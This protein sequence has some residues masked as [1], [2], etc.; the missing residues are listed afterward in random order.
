MCQPWDG[1][2]L[3]RKTH[4]AATLAETYSNVAGTGS[5][6]VVGLTPETV[7]LLR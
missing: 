7:I 1:D 6:T 5:I 3:A 4:S 2:R